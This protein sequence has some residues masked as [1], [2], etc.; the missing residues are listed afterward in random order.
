M[1]V[2][3]RLV[4][5]ASLLLVGC[6]RGPTYADLDA[7]VKNEQ[8]E[9]QKLEAQYAADTADTSK[10]VRLLQDAMTTMTATANSAAKREKVA[11]YQTQIDLIVQLQES[12]YSTQR[13]NVA[14]QRKKVEAL[15]EKRDA[16][17]E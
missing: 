7:A 17:M 3:R 14:T 8:A 9:L 12:L 2:V 10:Q 4:L 11:E 1:I 13:K 5:I 16:L 15:L 6:S